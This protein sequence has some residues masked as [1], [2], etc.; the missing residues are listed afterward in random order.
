MKKKITYYIASI[1]AAIAVA[2]CTDDLELPTPVPDVPQELAEYYFVLD[3]P[4]MSRSVEYTDDNHSEFTGGEM[5]GCFALDGNDNAIAGEKANA[6]YTVS[7]IASE[8]E[9]ID[10][11][12][13][14]VPNTPADKL[15]K[16]HAKYLFYYPYDKNVT[17]LDELKSLTHSVKADQR[18][19][20]DYEASDLLWDVAV[21]TDRFC[22]V[23]MDHAM[24]NIIIVIDGVEYDVEKGAV[25][26]NQPLT[27]SNINLTAPTLQ[28]MWDTE[29]GYYYSVDVSQPKVHIQAMY[30][31]YPTANDRFRAAVPANRTLKAGVQII[32]LWSAK[33]GNEKKFTLKN[34]ITLEA[35]K[36]YYFTLIKKGNPHPSDIKED[37]WVLDVLDPETGEPVGLLCREYVYF[38]SSSAAGDQRPTGQKGINKSDNTE[39]KWIDS[40]AWVFYNLI[41]GD[42]NGTPDLSTGCILR[43]VYDVRVNAK[44]VWYDGGSNNSGQAGIYWP[45]PHNYKNSSIVLVNHE[46]G[47][48]NGQQS[49]ILDEPHLGNQKKEVPYYM[50]GGRIYWNG[51]G[52][53][54]VYFDMPKDRNGNP[55]KITTDM[56]K[57]Q[58]HIAIPAE[59]KPY[60]SYDPIVT[61]TIDQSNCKVGF[62]L[63][64]YLI[65]TRYNN[66]I[67]QNEIRRYPIVKIGFNQFWMK[68]SLRAKTL[69]NGIPLHDYCLQDENGKFKIDPV[70]AN[71]PLYNAG[72]CYPGKDDK[73]TL[74]NPSKLDDKE[75][76]ENKM[77]ILYNFPAAES[78]YMVPKS[79]EGKS[80]YCMPTRGNIRT[81]LDYLGYAGLQKLLTDKHQARDNNGPIYPD[82]D[83]ELCLLHGKILY[84]NYGTYTPNVSGLDLRPDGFFRWTYSGAGFYNTG[85]QIALML[86]SEDL[87]I[88]RQIFSISIWNTWSSQEDQILNDGL[89]NDTNPYVL[90]KNSGE[91]SELFASRIF[92]PI[93]FFLKY[94]IPES[95]YTLY[96]DK[97]SPYASRYCNFKSSSIPSKEANTSRDVHVSV[98]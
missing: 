13:V 81:T 32:Q 24:A 77:T 23:E 55:L 53:K 50:H 54:I 11:K 36:N 17:T 39:T 65:D 61:E 2:G 90:R 8:N 6:C 5:L 73:S 19:H 95:Y 59:G 72:Y 83:D 15:D 18:K 35:G 80:E 76:E 91:P 44:E 40:Q 47:W 46:H 10:G 52:N 92:L 84:G 62:I 14:L 12:K 87:N 9:V 22:L 71:Q 16:G 58:G 86:Q 29:G 96:D 34:D 49:E 37:T 3:N 30:A 56:A 69:T 75:L 43:F 33:N 27:A 85:H 88:G 25:L 74:F 28:S 82:M 94:I 78:N 26:L 42:P 89:K 66:D 4:E 60:V 7:V 38:Q 70:S 48:I 21:P 31:D 63:P 67:K 79:M 93:R 64:H 41:D 57:T 1:L 68:Q 45:A 97:Y 20:E 51:E 98:E